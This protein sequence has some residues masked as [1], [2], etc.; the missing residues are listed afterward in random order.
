M[1]RYLP[2]L[3][4]ALVCLAGLGILW[5]QTIHALVLKRLFLQPGLRVLDVGCGTGLVTVPVAKRVGP[6]GEVVG[7]DPDLRRLHRAQERVNAAVLTNVRFVLA[8]AG[9]GKLEREHFDRAILS[10]VLGEM[11]EPEVALS[12]IFDTLKPGGV[13]SVTEAFP[14]PHRQSSAR[15]R[16]LGRNA[17]FAEQDCFGNWFCHTINLVKPTRF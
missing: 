8:A 17:G 5:R 4:V 14:D 15:V 16:K 12:E 10:G 3:T 2:H 11:S 7:L 1:K 6:S 13:L 9:E